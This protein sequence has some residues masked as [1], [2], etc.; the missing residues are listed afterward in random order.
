M[1]LPESSKAKLALIQRI[2]AHE[3]DGLVVA[4]NK[5]FSAAIRDYIAIRYAA[6]RRPIP[7][8]DFMERYHERLFYQALRYGH[9]HPCIGHTSV[10]R[11][12]KWVVV[13]AHNRLHALEWYERLFALAYGVEFGEDH[14][15]QADLVHIRRVP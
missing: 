2:N 14:V 12:G 4:S 1:E 11:D 8:A 5:D 9:D 15:T 13:P 6:H 3:F 10:L 7:H